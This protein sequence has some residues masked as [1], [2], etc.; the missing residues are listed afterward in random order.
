[1]IKDI[2]VYLGHSSVK[3]TELY[4]NVTGEDALEKHQQFG[5]VDNAD[6]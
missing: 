1:M 6:F 2:S 5:A 3:V 4:L